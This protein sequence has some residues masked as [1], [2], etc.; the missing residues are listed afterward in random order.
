M[1]LWHSGLCSSH[2]IYFARISKDT[3]D[4][5]LEVRSL[6]PLRFAGGTAQPRT[7]IGSIPGLGLSSAGG[8]SFFGHDG[9]YRMFFPGASL[10][11]FKKDSDTERNRSI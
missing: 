9:D 2:F 5:R 10:R 11:R 7:S 8:S 1:H 6:Y 4:A 3:I